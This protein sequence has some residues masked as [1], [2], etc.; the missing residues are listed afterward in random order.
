[1]ALN[2]ALLFLSVLLAL[3]CLFVAAL[4]VTGAAPRLRRRFVARPSPRSTAARKPSV[5]RWPEH[6]R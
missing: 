3:D 6:Y 2:A 4:L 1:M 5:W